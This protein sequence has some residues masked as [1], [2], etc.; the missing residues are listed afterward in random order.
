VSLEFWPKFTQ[1][2]NVDSLFK[3]PILMWDIETHLISWTTSTQLALMCWTL[4]CC[5]LKRAQTCLYYDHIAWLPLSCSIK[6]FQN[7]IATP[8][9][10]KILQT[11][12]M[13]QLTFALKAVKHML[14]SKSFYFLNSM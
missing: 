3:K 6:P 8:C 5:K 2:F 10:F 4:N 14:G 9:R 11:V 12:H 7:I 1:K 13:M